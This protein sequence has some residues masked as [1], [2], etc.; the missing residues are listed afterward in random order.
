MIMLPAACIMRGVGR[1]LGQDK[2]REKDLKDR[3]SLLPICGY[4][5]D[6]TKREERQ[7]ETGLVLRVGAGNHEPG[8]SESSSPFSEKG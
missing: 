3:L 8:L 5:E 4:N 6:T 2:E 7:V 1:R